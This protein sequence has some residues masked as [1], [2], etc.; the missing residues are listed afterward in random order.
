M[1]LRT[2]FLAQT[3]AL[4]ATA[5]MLWVARVEDDERTGL[6]IWTWAVTAQAVAY[7]LFANAG[8]LPV[9]MSALLGN[10]LGALSVAL[11]FAA[12]RRFARRPCPLWPL[13]AMV[14]AVS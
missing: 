12:I 6:S 13:A 11:F 7:G 8:R 2:L 4:G 14:V 9:W 3:A 5:A 10:A 1:D